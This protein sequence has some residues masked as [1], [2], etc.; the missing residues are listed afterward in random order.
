MITGLELINEVEDRLG[1]RQT[2]SLDGDL[3][4]D[5]RKLV[6]LL[7][8]VLKSI[9]RIDDWPLLR[10]DE[11]I[12]TIA[13][14]QDTEYLAIENGSATLALGASE[15][16]TLSFT[17]SMIGRAIQ[18]GSEKTI[19]RIVSVESPHSITLNKEWIGDTISDTK[20]AYKICQDQ[21]ALP[22]DFDRPAKGWETFLEPYH[23]EAVGPDEFK[24]ERTKRGGYMLIANPDRFTIYGYTDNNYQQ[25]LHLDP[26][27][28]DE[29][30]MNY[31]YYCNH[32][33]INT[34]NDRVLIPAAKLDAVIQGMIYLATRDYTDDTK[35]QLVLRDYM[36][37]LNKAGGSPTTAEDITQLTPYKGDKYK[38]RNQWGRGVRVNWGSLFDRS[39]R[40]GF[41]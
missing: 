6:R 29:V 28:E 12:K 3:R 8:R 37:S 33:E 2:S 19:Y 18:I 36:D 24:R 7:N 13:A 41:D 21:Y 27:P 40:V 23:V 14:L 1:W 31:S 4:P 5:S 10:K 20:T 38:R 17:E 39:D 9:Q 26:Y 30:V 34:D 32:P 16:G 11:E 35:V 22:E 25:V 15:E